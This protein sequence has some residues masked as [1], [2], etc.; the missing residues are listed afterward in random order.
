MALEVVYIS[1]SFFCCFV[2]VGWQ[3]WFFVLNTLKHTISFSIELW[4][5][6]RHE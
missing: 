4:K 3:R 1:F 5:A 6:W 2:F